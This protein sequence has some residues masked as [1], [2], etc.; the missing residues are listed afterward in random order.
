MPSAIAMAGWH[1]GFLSILPAVQTHARI[2]FR[3]L[4]ADHREEAI[5]EAI[6]AACAN[7]QRLAAAGKLDVAHPSTLARYAVQHVFRGRHVGG[8]QDTLRDPMSPVALRRGDVTRCR[9]NPSHHDWHSALSATRKSDIAALAAFRIDF[10]T[11]FSTF[12][13]RDRRII[14]ALASGERTS[15]VSDRFGLSEG[16]VSQLRRKYEREW[17]R[18]QGELQATVAA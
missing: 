13:R 16:R 12:T 3:K 7:Y 6:A 17:L 8:R 18:F 9:L 11:W 10:S 4:P 15:T 1:A 5:Q 2:Q 14:T